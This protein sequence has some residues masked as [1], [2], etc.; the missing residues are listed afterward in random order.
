M[1]KIIIVLALVISFGCVDGTDP[2]RPPNNPRK[3]CLLAMSL[4]DKKIPDWSSFKYLNYCYY[5]DPM[6]GDQYWNWPVVSKPRD[7]TVIYGDS[8]LPG[9]KHIAIV[10]ANSIC[11]IPW[12]SYKPPQCDPMSHIDGIFRK[13]R[14]YYPPDY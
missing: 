3:A 1:F 13:Y 10:C 6:I 9:E 5:N 11:H 14:F 2:V 4:V 8:S 12:H 7:G